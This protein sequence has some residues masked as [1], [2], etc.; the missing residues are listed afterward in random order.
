MKIEHGK[1]YKIK[2]GVSNTSVIFDKKI[3]LI[4]K[5]IKI[6]H[7]TPFSFGDYITEFF[8]ISKFERIKGVGIYLDELVLLWRN[9]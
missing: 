4:P 7:G 5:G 9:K 2:K 8:S 6:F 3:I 1:L